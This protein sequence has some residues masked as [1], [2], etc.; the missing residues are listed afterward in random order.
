MEST[1]EAGHHRV[2]TLIDY[3]NVVRRRKM[4]LITMMLLVPAAAVAYSVHQQSMYRATAGVWIN[5]SNLSSQITNTAPDPTNAQDPER[6]LQTQA[7]IARGYGVVQG[8]VGDPSQHIKGV[9]PD[10]GITPTAFLKSSSVSPDPVAD[11]VNFSV[12]NHDPGTATKLANAYG[13]Q[14]VAER[15]KLDT[16][17]LDSRLSNLQQQAI[18]QGGCKNSKS[19]LCK[20][21]NTQIARVDTL[22][23]LQEGNATLTNQAT[24][25]TQVQPA[26][27]KNLILAIVAGFILGL[28]AVFLR[29]ALDTRVRSE[30]EI[31]D[32]LGIPVLARLST[33]AR[34][35]RRNDELVT[36]EE[37]GSR[38]VEPYRT[39]RTN[40][41]FANLGV[42][43]RSL[44]IVSARE[45]EGK[46]TTVANL[47]VTL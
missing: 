21:I 3:V 1:P 40:F 5:R 27:T 42:R 8:V 19:A 20:V 9:V 35:L 10:T 28:A 44:L 4:T 41:D 14:F 25:A 24:T 16:A 6:L 13:Q 39:L 2:S 37:A 45:S 32:R 46:S 15:V 22:K 26:T 18:N 34:H 12:T 11:M 23:S 30:D 36:I 43:A 47:A 29:E 7:D 31:A 38:H 33:P 17:P